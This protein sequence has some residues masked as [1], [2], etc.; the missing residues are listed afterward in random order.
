MNFGDNEPRHVVC[1]T[2]SGEGYV[3]VNHDGA[4]AEIADKCPRCE[5]MDGYMRADPPRRR[6]RRGS[7]ERTPDPFLGPDG[8]R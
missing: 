6:A 4:L 2:C 3:F 7:D 1:P 5:G 8:P